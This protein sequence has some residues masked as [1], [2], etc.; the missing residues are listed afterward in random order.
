MCR[1]YA[2]KTDAL[3]IEAQLMKVPHS[4][5]INLQ[6]IQTIPC[7]AD[8]RGQVLLNICLPVEDLHFLGKILVNELQ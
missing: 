4:S 5:D 6:L 1:F 7:A 3:V 2:H 8:P